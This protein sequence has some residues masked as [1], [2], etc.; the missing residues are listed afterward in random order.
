MPPKSE[1]QIPK[2]FNPRMCF[3]K[4]CWGLVPRGCGRMPVGLIEPYSFH[5]T[6]PLFMNSKFFPPGMGLFGRFLNEMLVVGHKAS[7]HLTLLVF[8]LC[9]IFNHSWAQTYQCGGFQQLP[10]TGPPKYIDRFGN[11][12]PM[13]HTTACVEFAK[14]F[15]Q[16]ANAQF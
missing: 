2:S 5:L 11:N 14:Q 12:G 8:C 7:K 3:L 6:Q 9:A 15:L 4:S 1:I 13:C 10:V 16:W